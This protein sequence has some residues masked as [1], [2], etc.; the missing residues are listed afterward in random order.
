MLKNLLKVIVRKKRR[1]YQPGF[2]HSSLILFSVLRL[3]IPEAPH[4]EAFDKMIFLKK[5]QSAHSFMP[6]SYILLF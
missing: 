6:P 2:E 3:I 1:Q 5:N 4:K